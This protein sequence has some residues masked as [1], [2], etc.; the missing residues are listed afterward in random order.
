MLRRVAH[1]IRGLSADGVEQAK[2]GH[3]GMPLG[4]A[5]IAA[6]LFSEAMRHNPAS[7]NWADRDRFVLSAGHGSMLLYSVL[8]LTGYDMPMSELKR[9]RQLGSKAA[10]HPEYGLAPGIET[11]TGPLGQGF[12]NAVG[13]AIAERMLAERYNRPGFP[14]FNHYTYVISGDGCMMEGIT[15]EAAS[16]AGH[17]K[18]GRLIVFYDDNEISIEGSTDLAFTESVVDRFKAYGWHVQEIDGHDLDAIRNAIEAAKACTDKPSLIAARTTIA[19]GSPKLAGSAKAHGAPL[20]AEEVAGLKKALGLPEEPFSVPEEV[21]EYFRQRRVEWQR[22]K[23]RW[24]ALFAEW[25]AKYPDLRKDLDAAL[26]GRLPEDL[27]SMIAP[28]PEGT[29]IASRNS[30]GKVLQ[31]VAKAVPFLAGGSADLAP[32][33]K[34]YID[35]EGD[36]SPDDFT[37]R[38]FHFGIREH[39]MAAVC[40]GM[41]LHGGVRPYCATFLVFVDYLRPALRLSALMNQPVIYVLTHDSIY[42]GED[43]PTHEPIEQTESLRII[44]NCRVFRPA[45]ANEVRLAWIEAMKRKDG[46]TCLILTRQDLPTIAADRIPADGF[47]KGGYVLK[48]ESSGHPDLVLVAAGSEVSLCMEVAEMLEADGVKTRVVSM[49]SRE[50]FMSQ[51]KQYIESVLSS[52][53]RVA[54]EIGVGEGWY[55]ITGTSGMVYSLQRFGESGPGEQVAAHLGFTPEALRSAIKDRFGR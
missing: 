40:N 33:T 49:P 1:T 8:H 14:I 45:D 19:W 28:F 21:T 27:E 9:F 34:T 46:P 2:S 52:A 25:S 36:I 26:A 44:P 37:G 11:T 39:A 42:V 22:E 51:D 47:A 12:A 38:N 31:Q 43:G 41:S 18:L 7:P 54:V 50:L 5:D 16:L 13:M 55:Q 48:A 35:G 24:D 3:P 17:L 4:A 29:K 23:D 15:S 53:P 6:V 20:G 10:G 30:S 32:S